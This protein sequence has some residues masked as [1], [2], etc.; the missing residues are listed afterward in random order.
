[1]T[2]LTWRQFRLPASA[3]SGIIAVLALILVFTASALLDVPGV[4]DDYL[5][6]VPDGTGTLYYGGLMVMYVLPGVIG[7][8]WG[9]PLVARELET[10][11][12]R[13]VWNQTVTRTRWLA[14]KIGIAGLSAV[15]VAG[16]ASLV[17]GWWASPIDAA[18][19]V[20]DGEN[21]LPRINPLAFAGRGI[22]PMGYAAFAFVL[23]VAAGILL[24]RTVVAM[25][26]TL[27]LF[28]LVQIGVP[29]LVRPYIIPPV[30][31]TVTIS[32]SSIQSIRGDGTGRVL[33]FTVEQP[34]GVWLLGNQTID[35]AGKVVDPLPAEVATCGPNRAAGEL[36]DPKLM[37][38][39]L[40]RLDQLGYKQ[41]V[42]FQ[43]GS[44]FWP[45]QWAELGIFLV[46]TALLTWVCFRWTRHRLS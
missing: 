40:S 35:P 42:T 22:V 27:V 20:T 23:G 31:Q 1:M 46:L 24:R 17:V 33:S 4:G 29:A 34:T 21:F 30:E 14:A 6:Q 36:P 2:W 38:A 41:L 9:A 16:L 7:V 32:P 15:A 28:T 43:P 19:A 8:F 5:A 10:G 37:K 25:A 11:T 45:L 13:L 18:A 3:V 26:V 44:R 39:C 12:H